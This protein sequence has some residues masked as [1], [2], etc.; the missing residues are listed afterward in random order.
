MSFRWCKWECLF[1]L[2]LHRDRGHR[3]GSEFSGDSLEGY[4]DTYV[5]ASIPYSLELCKRFAD[6]ADMVVDRLR[7]R[8]E[9]SLSGN[10]AKYEHK[11][12]L[13]AVETPTSRC[14]WPFAVKHCCSEGLVNT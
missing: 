3:V 12:D 7:V 10:G 5:S 1:P 2:S 13:L 6:V 11:C 14:V 9:S 8:R 4:T